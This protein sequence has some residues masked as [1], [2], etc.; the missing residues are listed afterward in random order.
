MTKIF[1]EKLNIWKLRAMQRTGG[2]GEN[3][4]FLLN[5]PDAKDTKYDLHIHSVESDGEKNP[6]EI[7]NEA[8][9]N[10]VEIISIT[11]HDT[12]NVP[13]KLASGE[14]NLGSFSGKFINGV[15]VTSRL[16]GHPVE[17]LVY[18]YNLKNAYEE[19]SSLRFP[20]LDR[21]F[22]IFRIM[23][24]IGKRI[25]IVNDLNLTDKP[26][27][28]NDFLSVE[29]P[30]ENG[31]IETKLFSELGLDYKILDTGVFEFKQELKF[32]GKVYN[33]N[34]DGFNRK[35]YNFLMKN[36]KGVQFI[37]SHKLPNGKPAE[38]FGEFNRFVIQNKNSPLFIN[39]ESLWP[40]VEEVCDFAKN[41]GG[42]AILAHPYGYPNVSES[43]ENLVTS[44]YQAGVDGFEVWHGFNNSEQVNTLYNFCEHEG[45]LISSGSDTHGVPTRKGTPTPV[46][47]AP[48]F[49]SDD[50]KTDAIKVTPLSTRNLHAL[51]KGEFENIQQ[52]LAST[53]MGMSEE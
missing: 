2:R 41:V 40:K 1:E 52:K 25:K 12:I 47:F 18:D 36:E 29:F 39:D 13:L 46:G 14:Y 51:G 53:G 32:D 16:N 24:N 8:E 38:T 34:F 26:L 50:K 43:V 23:T 44:A 4:T 33:V 48:G 27:S 30:L 21:R 37:A 19:I 5:C 45:F 11:E 17:V 20:Y 31:K 3:L 22:K 10:G 35:L 7:G 9:K 15:E 6:T 49:E 42:V 28:L